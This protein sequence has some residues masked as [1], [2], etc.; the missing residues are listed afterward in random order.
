MRSALKR[1]ACAFLLTIGVGEV[2]SAG[3]QDQPASFRPYILAA[4]EQL[5]PERSG[6]GYD[7]GKRFT[8]DLNYGTECCLRASRPLVPSGSN[9]T[10]CVAAVAEVIVEALNEYGRRVDTSFN[11]LL[12]LARWNGSTR[13]HVIPNIFMYAGSDSAGTA[14]AL[15]RL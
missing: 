9:P 3:A 11:Q 2:S 7:I 13:T 5:D 4:I 12:P 8:R 14:F 10:M 15:Q 1:L 6:G